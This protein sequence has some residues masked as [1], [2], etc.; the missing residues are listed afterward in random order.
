MVA[1]TIN[2]LIDTAKSEGESPLVMVDHP[3]SETWCSRLG[4]V[5]QAPVRFIREIDLGLTY[6]NKVKPD[7]LSY[8]ALGGVLERLWPRASMMNLLDKGV[9][10]ASGTPMAV[11]I[12]ILAILVALGLFWILSPLQTEAQKIETMDREIAARKAEVKKIEALNKDM[13]NVKKEIAAIGAFKT[14]RP[15]TLIMLK[16]MT[17]S[18][19]K[20]AW[21]SRVRIA[22]SVIEIEGYAASATELLPK[23]EASDYFKKVDFASPTFRD[24]RMNAD[25]FTI[26]MEIEGLPE[27]IAANGKQK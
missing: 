8:T 4:Q 19:P 20:N 10:Q 3:L 27:E 17:R 18:L 25:R 15:M 16:E 7:K 1:E 13:D 5:V 11:S 22:E 23:L 9:H 6:P 12:G 2:A 24:T 26:K 21:L 14:S